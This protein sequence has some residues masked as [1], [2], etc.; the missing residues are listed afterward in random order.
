M[1]LRCP[2]VVLQY[3][4]PQCPCVLL[5]Q[6]LPLQCPC[7]LLLQYLL[8]NACPLAQTLEGFVPLKT[9]EELGRALVTLMHALGRSR[10][11]LADVVML[12]V[13]RTG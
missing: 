12:D 1:P 11:F 10:H 9:K 7:I 3:L 6:N 2:C 4:P 13:N 8:A 5:L